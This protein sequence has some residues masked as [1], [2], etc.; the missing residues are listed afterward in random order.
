MRWIRYTSAQM[1]TAQ[2]TL[3]LASINQL[4]QKASQCSIIPV[5]SAKKN[6]A[7]HILQNEKLRKRTEIHHVRQH[8]LLAAMSSTYQHKFTTTLPFVCHAGK[9]HSTTSSHRNH[10]AMH[11]QCMTK[12]YIPH[13]QEGALVPQ[14]A[15]TSVMP[16][17]IKPSSVHTCICKLIIRSTQSIGY[18]AI[19]LHL[20]YV[21]YGTCS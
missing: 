10:A 17:R 19:L 4:S 11:S 16:H 15:H 18:T 6:N 13:L 14:I 8:H 21:S 9:H 20:V 2:R 7:K 12:F 5:K 1:N 3:L